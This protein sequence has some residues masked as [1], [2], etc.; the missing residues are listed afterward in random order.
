M[1]FSF[2][3]IGDGSYGRVNADRITNFDPASQYLEI[4]AQ[5]FG[6]DSDALVAIY[7]RK[8]MRKAAR[9]DAEFVY[10]QRRGQLFFNPDKGIKGWGDGGL[11]AVLEGKPVLTSEIVDVT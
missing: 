2:E 1:S 7:K 4:D 9:L 11:F 5:S 8:K 10:H 3:I 6:V